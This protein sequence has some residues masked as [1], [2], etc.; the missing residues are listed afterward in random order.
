MFLAAN[1]RSIQSRRQP[2]AYFFN[3]LLAVFYI[4]LFCDWPFLHVRNLEEK[5]LFFTLILCSVSATYV[6]FYGD[7][8]LLTY[9]SGAAWRAPTSADTQLAT[10]ILNKQQ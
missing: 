4:F 5:L 3:H 10:V 1:V 8:F 6:V 2:K 9:D 7:S